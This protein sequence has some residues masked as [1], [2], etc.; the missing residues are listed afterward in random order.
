MYLS[1]ISVHSMAIVRAGTKGVAGAA[2]AAPDF[3]PNVMKFYN[4]IGLPCVL[5]NMRVSLDY[6]K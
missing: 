4:Q 5:T 6:T 1:Q 3:G 2:M